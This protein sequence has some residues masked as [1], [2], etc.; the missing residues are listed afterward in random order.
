MTEQASN[1]AEAMRWQIWVVARGDYLRTR[2]G[3]IQFFTSA[4]EA[5]RTAREVGGIVQVEGAPALGG[6][7]RAVSS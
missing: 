4:D 3:E 5:K 7:D 6:F 2:A 1:P